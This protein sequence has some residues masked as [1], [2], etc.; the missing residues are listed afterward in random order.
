MSPLL[1]L[2]VVIPTRNRPAALRQLLQGLRAQT[3]D[4]TQFEILVVDDGS[5][6]PVVVEAE[7]GERLRV[8]RLEHG[9]RSIARNHGASEGAGAVLLFLDDD[10]RLSGNVLEAHLSAQREWPGSLAVGAIRLPDEL[11]HTPFG[12]FR[13]ALEAAG[14]PGSRG[15]VRQRNFCTAGHM[16]MRRDDFL[17]LGGFDSTIVSAE[18]QD[19]ALRHSAAGGTIVYLPEALAV[20]DDENADLRSYCRRAE[21]GAEHMSAFCQRHPELQDNV[22]RLAVNG[23][24]RWADPG[25]LL[26][27]KIAKDVLGHKPAVAGLFAAV[28]AI[29]RRRPASRLLPRLYKLLLG[30]HLQK[31]FRRGWRTT[32]PSQVMP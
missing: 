32:P 13:Q 21:W 23:P 11:A 25:S 29:E 30:I 10:L 9:E 26:F 12:S 28:A 24:P 5:Q 4:R 2:S 17:A 8:L 18:D 15:P 31:G 14:I 6:P 7:P 1:E 16:S 27:K 20:H 3:L 19:L 22:D